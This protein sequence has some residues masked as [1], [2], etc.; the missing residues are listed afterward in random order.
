MAFAPEPPVQKVA[1][2]VAGLFLLVKEETG[3]CEKSGTTNITAVS[4]FGFCSDGRCNYLDRGRKNDPQQR[5]VPTWM[6]SETV[7]SRP[8][9]PSRP[10]P[11][12]WRPSP[13][14]P[15]GGGWTISAGRGN[16]SRNLRKVDG[17]TRHDRYVRSSSGLEWFFTSPLRFKKDAI[18]R[19]AKPEP[20]CPDRPNFTISFQKIVEEATLGLAGNAL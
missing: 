14:A 13:R 6:I 4:A 1:C 20:I 12:L 8:G 5:R 17:A 7:Q 15:H 19:T 16:F 10:K 9:I 3:C 18:A 11:L 2:N